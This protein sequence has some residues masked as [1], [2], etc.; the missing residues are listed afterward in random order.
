M[1]A[2]L[3][4]LL[5]DHV[6]GAFIGLATAA[7]VHALVVPES[8]V[9]LAMVLGMGIGGLMHVVLGLMLDDRE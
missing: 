6:G 3:G 4:F 9:A 7:G 5:A 8:D 2:S 1:R